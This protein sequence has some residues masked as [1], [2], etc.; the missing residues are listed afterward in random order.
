MQY[1]FR[2]EFIP[3][4]H[5]SVKI[6]NTNTGFTKAQKHNINYKKIKYYKTAQ[7]KTLYPII[8]LIFFVHYK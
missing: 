8:D 2:N 7:H 3:S 6:L 5:I 4:M 1:T